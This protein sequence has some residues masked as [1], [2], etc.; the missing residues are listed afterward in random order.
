MWPLSQSISSGGISHVGDPQYVTD[1]LPLRS[2][3]IILFYCLSRVFSC[4]VFI[5]W[6]LGS[7]ITFY[8]F[9]F[10]Q[11]LLNIFLT[12]FVFKMIWLFHWITREPGWAAR[13]HRQPCAHGEHQQKACFNRL[14]PL[15]LLCYPHWFCPSAVSTARCVR[16]RALQPRMFTGTKHNRG[17]CRF[18]DFLLRASRA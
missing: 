3:I 11:L 10:C 5:F 15:G 18:I 12:H 6:C 16:G 14:V 8:T 7:E 1:W 13:D 17:I 9:S 4:V 2:T